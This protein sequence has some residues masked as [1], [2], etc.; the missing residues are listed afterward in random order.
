[1]PFGD[2]IGEYLIGL[3]IPF[4]AYF[5]GIFIRYKVFA[6]TDSPPLLDQMLLGIPL[7]LTTVTVFL[8][9]AQPDFTNPVS[10]LATL[11]LIMQ[12]GLIMQ[13][14]ATKR[15]KRLMSRS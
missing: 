13:E 2:L 7:S 10:Y 6:A 12:Q 1:M 11:G 3:G 15:L 8:G 14:A 9:S 4:L 5:V